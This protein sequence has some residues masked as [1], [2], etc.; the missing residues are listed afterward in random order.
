M[1]RRISQEETFPLRSAVL[2][3]H[4]PF[5]ECILPTDGAAGIFHLGCF[6]EE[7]LICI[8][9]FLPEDYPEN[10]TG[11]FRLRG[12]AADPEFAG[13]G[14]GA[15]LINFAIDELTS[16]QASYIWCNARST[17][18]GFYKRLGF[19]II[20]EEFEVPGI[21]PHFDMRYRIKI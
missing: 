1:I 19:E 15:A 12:M 9:T 17:A 18:V 21:G 8:G 3:N 4:K 13:K 11:G 16:A 20:S 7:R 14:F 2:R 5:R 6:L 10:G